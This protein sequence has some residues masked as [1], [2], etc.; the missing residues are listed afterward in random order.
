[1]KKLVLWLS[2]ITMTLTIVACGGKE[3]VE[4]AA[5]TEKVN[6][7][8]FQFK[9]EFKDQ[10]T[11]L[12]N[13]Y[14]K[15]HKDVKINITT[16]GGGSDYG[17]ALKAKFVSGDEPA[18]F[19]IGGPQ[20]VKDW[21]S[22]LENLKGSDIAKLA[23][24][25]LL[26]GVTVGENV[27]GVPYNQEG[28]G[29]IY[30]KEIFKKAGIEASELTTYEKLSEAVKILDS[31]KEE[32]GLKAV[33]AFPAKETWVTGLHLSN[34]FIAPE[35][36]EDIIKTFEAKKIDF[37]YADQYKELVDLQNNYSVQPTVSLD[38]SQQVEKLFSLG[39]VAMI[40]QG[41]WAYGSISQVDSKLA[42]NISMIAI[43]ARGVVE[44]KLAVGV[45][46]YWAVNKTKDNATKEKAK[47][48]LNWVYSSKIGRDYVVNKFKFI[49]AYKGYE[50]EKIV[51]L[52]SQAVYNYSKDGKTINWVFMGYP[53][54]WGMDKL[55]S[56]LQK[57]ITDNATFDEVIK[58][59]K[60]AWASSRK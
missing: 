7:D 58:E 50:D 32:L 14:M 31:K 51:D 18:I 46:M 26:K 13:E 12:A 48:F 34:I 35:F 30:N 60:E 40:Q 43:P 11:E 27:Y 19:N 57:Y 38:Y 28:Y 33:F 2:I 45:P 52:L 21:E 16:V 41:N 54:S 56:S 10:F 22:K 23:I 39:Q 15:E 47:E 53:S 42:E 36:D 8:I 49:P 5:T 17:A 20:D 4:T 25:K 44:D 55:G 3:K 37:K 6:I 1:M 24:P 29:L 9:V 59:N